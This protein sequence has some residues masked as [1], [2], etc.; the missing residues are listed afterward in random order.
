MDTLYF[1]LTLIEEIW[2]Y[3]NEYE[4]DSFALQM[5]WRFTTCDYLRARFLVSTRY[6]VIGV[7]SALKKTRADVVLRLGDMKMGRAEAKC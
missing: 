3:V 1:I 2:S 7:L 4:C 6:W 5:A